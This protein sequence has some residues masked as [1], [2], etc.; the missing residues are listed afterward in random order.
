MTNTN[1]LT[2]HGNGTIYTLTKSEDR[3]FFEYEWI[4]KSDPLY[5]RYEK[6]SFAKGS[7][8]VEHAAIYIN[9][10]V[11]HGFISEQEWEKSIVELE[12]LLGKLRDEESKNG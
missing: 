9:V 3:W 12:V 5:S 11:Q 8:A 1:I 2:V 6:Y 4:A 10:A 7:D